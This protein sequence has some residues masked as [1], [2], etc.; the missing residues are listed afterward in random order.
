MHAVS[1][2]REATDSDPTERCGRGYR[3]VHRRSSVQ[4]GL[5]ETHIGAEFGLQQLPLQR[6]Y[7][8]QLYVSLFITFCNKLKS[9]MG[10]CIWVAAS[11]SSLLFLSIVVLTRCI[12]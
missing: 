6:K 12:P 7:A 1:H 11:F 10:N 9:S 2:Q 5:T 3:Y 4:G 8:M